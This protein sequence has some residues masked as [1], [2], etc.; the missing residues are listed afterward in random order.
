MNSSRQTIDRIDGIIHN[1]LLAEALFRSIQA[2]LASPATHL[3]GASVWRVFE[4]SLNAAIRDIEAHPRG[5]LFRRFLDYGPPN[6]DDPEKLTSDEETELSDPEC[7]ECIEFIFSHMVNRFKGELA[8]LLAIAPCLELICQ[9]QEEGRWTGTRELYLGDTIQERRWVKVGG[10]KQWG[11][12]T[13]GAD[14]LVMH[15]LASR[16]PKKAISV[17]GIVEVKSMPRSQTKLAGQIKHHLERLRGGV[18][19]EGQVWEQE[20]LAVDAPIYI[21]VIPSAWKLSRACY[22]RGS[23]LVYPDVDRPPAPTRLEKVGRSEWKV[24]LD[25]SKEAIEQ[26]AYEMTYWYMSQVGTAI[27]KSKAL[28]KGWEGMSPEEAGYN[29]I[30]MML[31]YVI[32]RYITARQGRR[33]IKLYNAYSFGYPAAMEAKDMLWPEDI[34]H[35]DDQQ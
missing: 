1:T 8:E 11:S 30:K 13:K 28:P 35:R 14:G 16:G 9:L 17:D 34:P 3:V 10:A 32:L 22:Y 5:K 2:G 4:G 26:A 24:T 31:Y 7:G 12:F 21:M 25:W 19:L 27:Y 15:R 6:P 20:A 33:A 18:R 23:K 29:A